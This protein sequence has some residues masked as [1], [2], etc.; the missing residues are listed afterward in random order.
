VSRGCVPQ[1]ARNFNE[2]GRALTTSSSMSPVIEAES[3]VRY[4]TTTPSSFP[5]LHS[6]MK[7]ARFVAVGVTSSAISPREA[8]AEWA[9]CGYEYSMLVW[10]F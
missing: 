3:K 9:L 1:C 8:Q 6:A 7:S 4:A 5:D 2:A 10:G